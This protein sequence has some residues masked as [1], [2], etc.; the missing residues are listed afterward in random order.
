MKER[1]RDHRAARALDVLFGHGGAAALC[2]LKNAAVNY[3]VALLTPDDAVV[4]AGRAQQ[5]AGQD[6]M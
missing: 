2:G 6:R 1:K 3:A 4:A 5:R